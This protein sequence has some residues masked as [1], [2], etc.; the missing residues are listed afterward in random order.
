MD[1]FLLLIFILAQNVRKLR[2]QFCHLFYYI[3][4]HLFDML[5][6]ISM[7]SIS[8]RIF[9]MSRLKQRDLQFN[10]VQAH[11]LLTNSPLCHFHIY[12]IQRISN[13]FK[14]L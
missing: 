4:S 11:D 6:V 1:T 14:L 10:E 5:L 8:D 3:K 13:I 7:T 2:N 9:V 12:L